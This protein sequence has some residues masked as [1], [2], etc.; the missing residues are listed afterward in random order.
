MTNNDFPSS[1]FTE[2]IGNEVGKNTSLDRQFHD[3]REI[4]VSRNGHT[5]LSYATRYGKRYA[6]KCLKPEYLYTPTYRQLLNKEF[7]IGLR[8][9]HPNIC[10]TIG[11]EEIDGYGP[12]IIM[13]YIDGST[14]R[15]LIDNH[16]LTRS[17]AWQ[18]VN[19]LLDALSYLH[20]KEIFHRDLK[21]Q[22]IML[23]HRTHD[24]RLIDF[25]LS[26]SEAFSILKAPAG[27]I[28][29]IAPEQ[30]QGGATANAGADIFSLGKVMQDMAEATGDRRLMHIG[31]LCANPV[32]SRRPADIDK[33]KQ[34]ISNSKL[35]P[36]LSAL[37]IACALLVLIVVAGLH[38]R[39]FHHPTP[40]PTQQTIY[41]DSNEVTDIRH[42]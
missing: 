8:L 41:S 39:G 6:L 13:E 18:T 9:D 21:P 20:S 4:Y 19:R 29:Y 36:W 30:L 15:R 3:I 1:G 25:S 31:R 26:D 35:R 37:L 42:I 2:D 14:L 10:H 32:P 40:P 24:M 34:A 38:K 28:G 16:R 17:L 5:R 27:T 23:T 7:E 33:V 11:M 12:T 22:N